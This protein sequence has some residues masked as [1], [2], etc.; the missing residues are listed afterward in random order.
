MRGIV[1][2]VTTDSCVMATAG[3]PARRLLQCAKPEIDPLFREGGEPLQEMA[4]SW[5]PREM[6]RDADKL[7]DQA[8]KAS[9]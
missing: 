9:P 1:S 4:A 8:S 6:N 5:V 2:V 7:V 3:P